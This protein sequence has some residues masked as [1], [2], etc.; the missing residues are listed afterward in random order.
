MGLRTRWRAGDLFLVRHLDAALVVVEKRAGILTH[1]GPGQDEPN[2]LSGLRRL[3]GSRGSGGRL[4]AV[5]RLDRVVSG[6]LAFAR[7]ERA[8]ERL[9]AQFEARTVQRRYVAAV[10]GSP[11]KAEGDLEDWLDV[12]AL[13]VRVVEAKHPGAR[14]AQTHFRVREPLPK[15]RASVLGV[16]LKTGLRNQIRVQM[17]AHGFP[18]LG[19]RKY[20]P[21]QPQPQRSHRI[22]LHAEALQ[23]EHPTTRDTLHFEAPLPPDLRRWLDHLRRSPSRGCPP[24]PQSTRR[25]RTR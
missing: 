19:E 21:S 23:L 14:L 24:A 7:N 9:R 20:H 10:H 22:F 8:F 17:A 25:R 18:L 5:H 13:T 6:L 2:V 16:T 3:L 15:G 1:A 12:S 11:P 4:M